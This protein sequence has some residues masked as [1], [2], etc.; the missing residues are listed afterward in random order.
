MIQKRVE[1]RREAE[2][3]GRF[4]IGEVVALA[5]GETD[6][7]HGRC[8]LDVV[9]YAL[10]GQRLVE[11]AGE[12]VGVGADDVVHVLR[13]VFQVGDAGSHGHGVTREGTRLVHGAERGEFFHD[14]AAAT[15]RCC[16]HASGDD[17]AKCGEVSGDIVDAVPAVVRGAE[18][19][20]DLVE[21]EQRTVLVGHILELLVEVI[22][23][24]DGTHV[25]GSCLRDNAGNVLRILLKRLG[26]GINI[27][28]GHDDSV[29][30]GGTRH[31]RRI[32]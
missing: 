28:V 8:A 9:V 11:N 22:L 5:L 15:E 23:R 29:G 7:Q 17:L 20:H 2:G 26:H 31:T 32:R 12:P 18:S 1:E 19:R 30:C 14:L 6:G 10:A 4:H 24:R 25:A 3:L 27:V 21:D 16:R 13:G